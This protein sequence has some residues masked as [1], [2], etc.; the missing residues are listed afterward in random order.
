MV[1][2][3]AGVDY[4]RAVAAPVLIAHKGLDA[5]D[6]GGRVCTGKRYPHE[7][8]QR[9]DHELA[10]IDDYNPAKSDEGVVARKGCAETLD[11]GGVK[12]RIAGLT[13]KTRRLALWGF[14]WQHAWH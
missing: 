6:I 4:Q 10:V 7:V 5:M 13:S 9:F 3:E 8:A 1:W 2:L 12:L 14:D 11:V